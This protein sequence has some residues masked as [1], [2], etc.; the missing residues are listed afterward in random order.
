MFFLGGFGRI[1]V[2]AEHG[3]AA[4]A[5]GHARVLQQ[6]DQVTAMVADKKLGFAVHSFFSF[7]WFGASLRA[8]TA[9]HAAGEMNINDM[10]N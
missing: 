8:G 7:A 10:L 2:Q 1:G 4:A 5:D 9:F 6:V 3:L